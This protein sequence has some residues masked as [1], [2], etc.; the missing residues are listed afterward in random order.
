VLLT[1]RIYQAQ[2]TPAASPAAA[3]KPV[4][5]AKGCFSSIRVLLLRNAAFANALDK[6]WCQ[7]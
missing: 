2:A 7:K 3:P 5:E 4:I 6:N 1:L